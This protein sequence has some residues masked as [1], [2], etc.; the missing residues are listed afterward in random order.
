MPMGVSLFVLCEP[1]LCTGICR[2]KTGKKRNKT[3]ISG[4]YWQYRAD[5]TESVVMGMNW[6]LWGLPAAAGMLMAV[7]GSINGQVSRI[8]GT[9]ESNFVMHLVGLGIIFV[10]LFVVGIG[11]G[12]LA[13][14]GEVPWYGYLSGAIN[15]AIIYGVMVSIPRLGA[16]PAT[17]AIIAGQV[18]TSAIIDWFGLFG[19]EKVDFSL[20][21]MLG[22]VVLAAGVWLMLNR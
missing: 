7:Q 10:L 13:A 19:L 9:L 17:T 14:I 16:A 8:I 12:D 5:L 15:V 21:Q 6:L 4:A 22:I 1:H 2:Y 18:L 3:G 11:D 20:L